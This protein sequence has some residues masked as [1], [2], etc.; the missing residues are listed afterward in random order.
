MREQG[1]DS[2]WTNVCMER[3]VDAWR[4]GEEEHFDVNIS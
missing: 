4:T 1:K 3:G 2:G